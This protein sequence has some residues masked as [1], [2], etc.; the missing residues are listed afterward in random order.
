M[1][2]SSRSKRDGGEE[3]ELLSQHQQGVLKVY[4]SMRAVCL[5]SREM[6]TWTVVGRDS[7]AGWGECWGKRGEEE[8]GNAAQGKMDTVGWG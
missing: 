5:V 7:R 8:G 6:I 1:E 2:I 4:S 3:Q